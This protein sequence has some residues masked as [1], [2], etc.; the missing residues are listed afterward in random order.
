MQQLH[1]KSVVFCSA[2]CADFAIDVRK[3]IEADSLPE[4]TA[5][6]AHKNAEGDE[7]VHFL[8]RSLSLRLPT[9]R[10]E[11]HTNPRRRVAR[12]ITSKSLTFNKIAE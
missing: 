6:L 12:G 8:K 11:P 4:Y 9:T 1:E 3:V 5:M 7:V 10:G 2:A